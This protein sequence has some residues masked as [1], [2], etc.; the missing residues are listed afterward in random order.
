MSEYYSDTG[1]EQVA[2]YDIE[3]FRID[4]DYYGNPRYVVHFGDLGIE[5]QD[6][7]KVKGLTKYKGDWFGGGY[8]FQSYSLP[9]TFTHALD[10]V[11]SYYH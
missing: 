6:Y 4:N 2:D 11:D 1:I 7:G 5:Q 8:V 10:L 3:W 9:E